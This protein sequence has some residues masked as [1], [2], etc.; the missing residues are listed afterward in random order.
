MSIL[1]AT[2]NIIN[3]VLKYLAKKKIQFTCTSP[4]VIELIAD[5][6]K[7]STVL[8]I[9]IAPALLSQKVTIRFV[10]FVRSTADLFTVKQKLAFNPE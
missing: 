1:S 8:I 7:V 3:A 9:L 10:S 4:I 2:Q 6:R 5:D